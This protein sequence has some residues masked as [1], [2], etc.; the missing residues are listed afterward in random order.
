MVGLAGSSAVVAGAA[1][2]GNSRQGVVLA[3]GAGYIREYRP[4]WRFVMTG[5]AGAEN[6]K[7]TRGKQ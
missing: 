3:M 5:Y 6:G 4:L 7:R 1:N 2:V